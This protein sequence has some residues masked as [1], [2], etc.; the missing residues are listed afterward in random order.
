MQSH[1]YRDKFIAVAVV[2]LVLII[3]LPMALFLSGAISDVVA[4]VWLTVVVLCIWTGTL[5]NRIRHRETTSYWPATERF[6][7]TVREISDQDHL[8]DHIIETLFKTIDGAHLSIWRYRT[9]DNVLAMLRSAGAPLTPDLS[10]LPFDISIGQ[11]NGTQPVE[12]LPESALRQGLLALP[13][14]HITLLVLGHELIGAVCIGQ[15]QADGVVEPAILRWLDFMTGHLAL[16]IKNACLVTD[17][18]ETITKLQLAYRRTIDAEQEERRHLAI[19]LHDDILSRLTTLSMSLRLNRRRLAIDPN[20]VAQDLLTLEEET[21]HLN[22]RLREITQGLHPTV[23]TDLGLIA[24]LQA[25]LDSIGKQ[26]LPASAPRIITLTAQGFGDQRIGEDKLE[27]DLYYITRQAIDNALFHAHADQILIH[28]RWGQNAIS[29]TVQDTGCGLRD[30]PEVLMG[31]TGHLGLLSMNERT[32]AWRGRLT[33]DSSPGRGTT[34]HV[35]IP[36]TQAS[37]VLANL[38]AHTYHLHQARE[39]VLMP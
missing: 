8:L 23:L 20:P 2:L 10:E 39:P 12:Q 37:H 9:D 4:I 6:S 16:V 7:Q 35:R 31:Q 11:L 27:T 33:F 32:L 14:D 21:Q 1:F 29:I 3:S 34:V 36:V 38:Q 24:A 30:K 19:E 22:R 5:L 13:V 18:E 15:D 26:A 25:Y 17:L 28:L